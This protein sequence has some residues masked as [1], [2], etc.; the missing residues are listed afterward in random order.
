MGIEYLLS[1]LLYIITLTIAY[2]QGKEVKEEQVDYA[3]CDGYMQCIKD[4][5]EDDK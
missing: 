4:A 2:K 1:A 5:Q 3:W